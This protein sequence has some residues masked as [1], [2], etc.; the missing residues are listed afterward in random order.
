[1]WYIIRYAESSSGDAI[2]ENDFMITAVLDKQ[3]TE[4]VRLIAK[5]KKYKLTHPRSFTVRY[6]DGRR[7]LH[8]GRQ[9]GGGV[10]HADAE[11]ETT[12]GH[13]HC[14]EHL[15][16]D[17]VTSP[18]SHQS[19]TSSEVKRKLSFSTFYLLMLCV[20]FQGGL[21]SNLFGIDQYPKGV[22]IS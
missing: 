16:G 11:G 20:T 3:D 13:R 1:M 21:R 8:H 15:Q 9:G 18:V 19:S 12:R 10:G 2:E 4:S 6:L 5:V 7:R 22:K 14:C 17:R